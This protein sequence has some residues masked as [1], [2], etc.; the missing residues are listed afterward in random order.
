MSDAWKYE[1]SFPIAA[2]VD[3]LFAALTQE[4][5]LEQW[6]A[7]HA[8]VDARKGGRMEFWGRH[9]VGTPKEGDAGGLITDFEAGERLAFEWKLFGVPSTV[10]FTLFPE[11][12][13]GG[14]ST[15]VTVGHDF[16]G[17]PD[18]PRPKELVDDWWRLCLGNLTA[19]TTPQGEVMRVDFADAGPEI[20]LSLH[21]EAPP[22]KVFRALTEPGCLNQWMAKDAE[23][24]LRVGG[25]WDLGWDPPEGHA[26]PGMKILEL[27]ANEK[28][29]VSWP[30]WRGDASVP[31]QSV[32]WLLE[33]SDGGTRVTLIHAGFVRAADLSDYPFGWDHFMDQMKGV[34]EKL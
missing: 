15:R 2:G 11:E 6:F 12:A 33:P 13:D 20:R 23:V 17:L 21:V 26:G 29:T 4:E 27:V 30:D 3:A 1:H 25:S 28:L 18:V 7:E 31:P 19:Y 14:P 32:T 8:S 5:E 22:D 34:A 10:R 24:D 9:T 16:E